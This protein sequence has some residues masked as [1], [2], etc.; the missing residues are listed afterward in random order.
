MNDL[1]NLEIKKIKDI[2][3]K[4]SISLYAKIDNLNIQKT[5]NNTEFMNVTLT[6]ETGS[7]SAKKWNVLEKDKSQFN[8]GQLV[9]ITG[10]GNEYNNK[11]QLIIENIRL[12][13]ENDN[14][15]LDSFYQT[16][17]ISQDSLK[18]NIYH[19]LDVIKNDKLSQLTKT[20][21]QKYEEDFFLYPAAT[22]NHH[23]HISG[24]A[25][26]VSTMLDVA[27]SIS[28]SYKDIN[29]DLLYSG[30]ILHDIGKIQ[31]LSNH[32][33][34]QYTTAGKLI[35]HINICFEEI[36]MTANQLKIDGEEVI[37]LQHLVLSHHGLLEYGSP[38]TP[39][40]KEAELLHLIDLLDSRMNMIDAELDDTE[41]NEFTKRIYSLDGKSYYKHKL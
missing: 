19:Y 36:R 2:K 4:D 7:I 18:E 31:E 20:I 29:L 11:V 14:I 39:M 22:R 1:F 38:K 26:H 10:V 28:S 30:I 24:L 25:Y 13:D 3:N 15:D 21:F 5:V 41:P 37:L 32:L 35:G 6:D 9:F 34:P 40:L 33:A 16:A 12:V 17:P 23:A 8:M 27:K